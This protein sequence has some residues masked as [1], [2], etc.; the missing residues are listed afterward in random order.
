MAVAGTVEWIPSWVYGGDCGARKNPAAALWYPFSSIS[1][2]W[3]AGVLL[4]RALRH[5]PHRLLTDPA[6]TSMTTLPPMC[7]V[8]DTAYHPV[9]SATAAGTRRL[10]ARYQPVIS[11]RDGATGVYVREKYCSGKCSG[12]LFK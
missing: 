11:W 2:W 3:D 1:G 7:R 9:I 10:P 6:S 4:H 12:C 5:Y 8:Y